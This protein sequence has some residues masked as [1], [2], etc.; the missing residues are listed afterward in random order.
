MVVGSWRIEEVTA[1]G[2]E[3]IRSDRT[4]IVERFYEGEFD[5]TK[6]D[7]GRRSIPVD[8]H[9]IL[10]AIL[11]ASWQRLKYRKPGRSHFHQRKGRPREPAQFAARRHLK[12][13]VRK[14]LRKC[15]V[16]YKGGRDSRNH[17]SERESYYRS[18][19]RF[20]DEAE[21]VLASALDLPN[22]AEP[23]VPTGWAKLILLK[24]FCAA[25]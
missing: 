4:E 22:N 15:M 21:R 25:T 2:W 1:L 7:A 6:T 17:A 5:D 18:M 11:D 24:M 9:G 13:T 19:T 20:A 12:P 23:S 16:T 8:S 10:R 3:R 14:E